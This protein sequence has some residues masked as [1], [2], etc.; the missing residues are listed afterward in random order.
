MK[1][2]GSFSPFGISVHNGFNMNQ[3][4]LASLPNLAAQGVQ[5]RVRAPAGEFLVETAFSRRLK[6]SQVSF[7]GGRQG[8]SLG[9]SLQGCSA[10]ALMERMLEAQRLGAGRKP[11][12]PVSLAGPCVI[13]LVHGRQLLC[14]GCVRRARCI[15]AGAMLRGDGE[16][17]SGVCLSPSIWGRTSSSFTVG[18]RPVSG[19]GSCMLADP[20]LNPCIPSLLVRPCPGLGQL[21]P[22]RRCSVTSQSSAVFPSVTL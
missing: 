8:S 15:R 4:S 10:A 3:F 20:D 11:R 19:R 1:S 18:C 9:L 6:P 16:R 17:G 13:V 12:Q 5:D 7:P 14:R 2:G 21:R 22:R